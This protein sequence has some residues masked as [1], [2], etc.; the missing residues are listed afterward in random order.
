MHSI[1]ARRARPGNNLIYVNEVLDKSLGTTASDVE[2]LALVWF[3]LI[4]VLHKGY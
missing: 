4:H 1:V 3:G 2:S